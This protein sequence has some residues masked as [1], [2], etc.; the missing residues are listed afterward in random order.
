MLNVDVR[1]LKWW[2]WPINRIYLYL[3]VFSSSSFGRI[4]IM[5]L[6]TILRKIWMRILLMSLRESKNLKKW[7]TIL[8]WFKYLIFNLLKRID[9]TVDSKL[10][11]EP[12][13]FYMWP[14]ALYIRLIDRSLFNHD[15]LFCSWSW[16][17]I[18]AIMEF[19]IQR[20]R[21]YIIFQQLLNW[22][23]P[24]FRPLCRGLGFQDKPL[25]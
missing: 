1:D 18:R 19:L 10:I 22:K 21:Q 20:I 16:C 24:Q 7:Q 25:W 6:K 17:T 5:F 23:V 9:N 13:L 3:I 4:E 2:F 12:F 11:I 14:I 15:L 8:L